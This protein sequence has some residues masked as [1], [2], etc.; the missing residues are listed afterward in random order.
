MPLSDLDRSSDVIGL[1]TSPNNTP[2]QRVKLAFASS[3]PRQPPPGDDAIDNLLKSSEAI[4]QHWLVQSPR[5][6]ASP[7]FKPAL[8][9]TAKDVV[10]RQRL[11]D[12]VSRKLTR[13]ATTNLLVEQEAYDSVYSDLHAHMDTQEALGHDLVPLIDPRMKLV[14]P[15]NLRYGVTHTVPTK[16]GDRPML[17]CRSFMLP[18]GDSGGRSFDF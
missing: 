17:P 9:A 15:K 12:L 13:H 1:H 16:Y 4:G 14:R 3:S 18:N 7:R 10:E 6:A 11:A 5:A 2:R 8:P